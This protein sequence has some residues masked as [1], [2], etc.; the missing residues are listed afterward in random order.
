M[1]GSLFPLSP[2]AGAHRPMVGG[3]RSRAVAVADAVQT[4]AGSHK[5][6]QRSRS[7]GVGDKIIR[8]CKSLASICHCSRN[9]SI[10]LKPIVILSLTPCKLT[11]S[12]HKFRDCARVLPTG[13]T[14]CKIG[15]PCRVHFAQ[16]LE[17]S[18][19]W[20]EESGELARPSPVPVSSRC[21]PTGAR[22]RGSWSARAGGRPLGLGNCGPP[23]P[24][25]SPPGGRAPLSGFTYRALGSDPAPAL[26]SGPGIPAGRGL[27]RYSDQTLPTG[28]G[29]S[30]RPDSPPL[31]SRIPWLP[32]R[33]PP[34]GHRRQAAAPR[35]RLQDHPMLP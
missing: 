18:A 15:F 1:N 4:W 16:I 24:S 30:S 23:G 2:K 3:S 14:L 17:P 9:L 25:S 8:R 7:R 34:E 28:P 33:K 20:Q 22:S 13:S 32:R 27:P 6:R 21:S 12:L 29:R 10:S 19:V 31:A 26:Q 5:A 11:Q 35:P